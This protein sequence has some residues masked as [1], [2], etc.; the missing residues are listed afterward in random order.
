MT[1]G[2]S[3]I[4]LS[5]SSDDGAIRAVRRAAFKSLAEEQASQ[6]KK[7]IRL[8]RVELSG[9]VPQIVLNNQ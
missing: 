4:C 9:P 6:I 5:I 8:R 7:A 3:R 1:T 2:R